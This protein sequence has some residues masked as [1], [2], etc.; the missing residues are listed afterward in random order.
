MI[1]ISAPILR[2]YVCIL[3]YMYNSLFVVLFIIYIAVH[4]VVPAILHGFL[5]QVNVNSGELYPHPNSIPTQVSSGIL[6]SS[7][8]APVE[9]RELPLCYVHLQGIFSLR[10]TSSEF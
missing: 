5:V 2:V 10:K 1:I 4:I 8:F 3:S 9:N 7:A 6:D